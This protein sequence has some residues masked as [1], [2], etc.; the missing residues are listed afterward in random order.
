MYKLGERDKSNVIYH[1]R[2]IFGYSKHNEA[3]RVLQETI[4]LGIF[5][6]KSIKT[7]TLKTP[8]LT[9]LGQIRD[10]ARVGNTARKFLY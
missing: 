5:G 9:T 3:F 1:F 6:L 8:I 2:E 7:S 10:L 4:S